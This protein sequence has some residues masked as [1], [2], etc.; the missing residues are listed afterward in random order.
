VECPGPITLTPEEYELLSNIDFEPRQSQEKLRESCAAA[1]ELTGLLI[2][3]HGNFLPYLRYFIFGPDLPRDVIDQFW[4]LVLSAGFVTGGDIAGIRL[5]ARSKV[6]ERGLNL[7]TSPD[8]FFKLAIECG[9][10]ASY[11]RTIRDDVKAIR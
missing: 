11:A 7:R 4:R 5:F 2:F 6:R 9:L 1:A 10:D 3:G 8:E